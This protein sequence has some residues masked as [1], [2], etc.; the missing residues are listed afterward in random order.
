MA[1][2]RLIASSQRARVTL[3][4]EA[5]HSVVARL[6]HSP[7]LRKLPAMDVRTALWRTQLHLVRLLNMDHLCAYLVADYRRG[8]VAGRCKQFSHFTP[9][10]RFRQAVQNRINKV[11][12][13]AGA[14]P[15]CVV[16]CR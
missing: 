11:I 9:K 8:S 3:G 15:S 14:W 2:L 5:L 10:V 16:V 4:N 1:R 6:Y 7:A 12:P 13:A